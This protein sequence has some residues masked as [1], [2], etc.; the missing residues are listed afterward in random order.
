MIY[1]FDAYILDI[2]RRELRRAGQ[3]L[4]IEPQVF[5]LLAYLVRHRDRVVTKQ[6]LAEHIWP[7]QSGHQG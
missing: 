1:E 7:E 3:L 6:E 5:D 2:D 4:A